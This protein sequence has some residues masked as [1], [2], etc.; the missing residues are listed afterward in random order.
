MKTETRLPFM[1]KFALFISLFGL[2]TTF[3]MMAYPPKVPTD[4]FL[5]RPLIGFTFIVI[6]AAGTA[7]ALS[8]RK[9]S[10]SFDTHVPKATSIKESKIVSSVGSKA[11]HPNCGRFSA[12][13]I[14]FRRTSYCA[15][16]TGLVIGASLA[17]AMSVAYFFFGISIGGFSV[18]YVAIGPLGPL[19]GFIQFTFKGWV[20]VA[21]N[22]FFVFGS[23]LIVI[24]IDQHIGSFFVD[25]YMIGLVVF[26]I[27]TRI[28]ISQW[29]HSRICLI[30]N[31]QCK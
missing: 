16:C 22:A 21:A 14:R 25:L 15:A 28:T 9:C 23:S 7:A 5:R 4:L 27:M 2:L 6:C 11:H 13:T 31:Y 1:M 26:W 30:C 3:L 12:H 19:V 8:P 29:D 24:G 10:T 20:R 17:V 18:L